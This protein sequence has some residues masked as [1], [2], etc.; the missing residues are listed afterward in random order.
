[1]TPHVVKTADYRTLADSL[2]DD[3]WVV[4]SFCADW[5]TSCRQY[6]PGYE[7]MAKDF[8]DVRFFWV[9]IEDHD[10]LMGDVDIH[11]FPTLLMQRGDTV[12]FYSCLTADAGQT[13]RILQ[14]LL[15][16]SP[17]ELRRQ[18]ESSEERRRWQT[19]NNFRILL[20]NALDALP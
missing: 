10:D 1:M 19:E 15:D 9:D 8:P 7:A 6:R 2:D 13:A 17:E 11:K 16:E 4:V 12:A 18:A 3:G 14:S 5:C 20:E